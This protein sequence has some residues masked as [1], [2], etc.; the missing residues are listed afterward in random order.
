MRMM[1]YPNCKG[2]HRFFKIARF[3]ATE[4]KKLSAKDVKKELKKEELGKPFNQK[5]Y[6]FLLTR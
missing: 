3:F 6:L 4:P 2:F 5:I 1:S